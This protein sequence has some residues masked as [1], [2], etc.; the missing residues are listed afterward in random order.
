MAR[1]PTG[2]P[3]PSPI[4]VRI[5]KPLPDG[6]SSDEGAAGDEGLTLAVVDSANVEDGRT[7]DIEVTT[8]FKVDD[9]A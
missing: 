9:D 4:F 2:I 5:G 3:T 6:V 7:V 1:T 8:D